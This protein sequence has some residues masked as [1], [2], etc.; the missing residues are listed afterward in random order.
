MT[1]PG[2]T[3]GHDEDMSLIFPVAGDPAATSVGPLLT[4]K[5]LLAG[6]NIT[7]T[8]IAGNLALRID[9]ATPI[10]AGGRTSD[11]TATTIVNGAYVI[12]GNYRNGPGWTTTSTW[13]CPK[14]AYYCVNFHFGLI[15][16]AAYPTQPR[17]SVV[18]SGIAQQ[19]TFILLETGANFA[20]GLWYGPVTVG[21]TIR[22]R[23]L[24][25]PTYQYIS[26]SI[27]ITECN[28]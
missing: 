25:G 9:A 10:C 11:T 13:T 18:R 28:Q 4:I 23:N 1:D 12:W 2:V 14:T 27:C 7:I 26:G 20:S 6:D 24:G 17:V 8:S 5:W 3:F 15:S 22:L 16:G 19:T 21:Q